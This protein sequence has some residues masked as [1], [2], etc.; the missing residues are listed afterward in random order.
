M[1]FSLSLSFFSFP[2]PFS[3][4]FLFRLPFI[5][6]GLVSLSFLFPCIESPDWKIY[7]PRNNVSIYRVADL[8]ECLMRRWTMYRVNKFLAMV[9]LVYH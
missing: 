9:I 1:M 2:F 5:R 7:D 6:F 8:H 3:R 4:F